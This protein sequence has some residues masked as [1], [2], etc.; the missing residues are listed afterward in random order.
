MFLG[1]TVELLLGREQFLRVLSVLFGFSGRCA[2]GP[3]F[4]LRR[5]K[6]WFQ[7]LVRFR[8]FVVA[9]QLLL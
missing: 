2:N 6:G 9:G 4:I 3:G 1:F 8:R 5:L 7:P